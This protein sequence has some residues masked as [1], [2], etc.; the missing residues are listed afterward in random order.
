MKQSRG[1]FEEPNGI[2]IIQRK[3]IANGEKKIQL[4]RGGS[5]NRFLI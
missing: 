2:S 5:F 1:C 4:V 3:I